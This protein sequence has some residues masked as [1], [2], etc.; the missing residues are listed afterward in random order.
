MYSFIALN[1][2]HPKPFA[3]TSSEQKALDRQPA[4]VPI[5]IAAVPRRWPV[6]IPSSMHRDQ[7]TKRSEHSQQPHLPFRMPSFT[8]PLLLLGALPLILLY[9]PTL[10]E[11]YALWD[12]KVLNSRDASDGRIKAWCN[13]G[14]WK[15]GQPSCLIMNTSNTTEHLA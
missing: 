9:I 14:W 11:P 1:H 12:P 10:T 8:I 7:A 5:K 15:V 3:D 13:M 2:S 6:V 4:P